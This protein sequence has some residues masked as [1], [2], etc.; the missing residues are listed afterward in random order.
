MA[1]AQIRTT[2]APVFA[3][4]VLRRL[5][6]A[7]AVSAVGD[8]MSAVGVAWLAIRI[9]S[10]ADS[11]LVVGV[12]VAAYTL[13]GA[14]G[15]V[16]LARPLRALSGRHLVAADAALRAVTL[17]MIPLLYAF[18]ALRAGSYVALLA[19]S[20]LLH[21]WGIS[22]QYTLVA[23]HLP[24]QSR[25]AANSLLSGAG[26]AALVIG[27]LLAGLLVA[28]A[29]PAL[30]VAA[31]AA[32]FAIRAVAAATARGHRPTARPADAG[33]ADAGQPDRAAGFAAIARSRPLAGLL[34]LTVVYFFL[35]GP[36]E[37]ALPLYVTGPLGGG[38]GLLGL[39]WTV[40]GIG[41]TA[42]SII[43]GLARRLPVW[44]VLVAA[45]IG[46]GAV[47]TPL[48]LL[49]LAIPALACFAAGGLL[50]APYPALSATLFQ[51]ESPPQL[52]SQ[53]LAARG[54]LTVLAAPL[55]TALGGPLTTWLGAQHT[56]LAS[57]AA[58][59]ATGLAATAILITR[60]PSRIGGYAR[61]F[62]RSAREGP[63]A[64]NPSLPSAAAATRSPNPGL[65]KT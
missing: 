28:A 51:R 54:A 61:I 4:P 2:V 27:P 29:G 17:S 43:A 22:G 11:G 24:P 37:V 18:G 6:P 12:A 40:F 42:G 48:G 55:G 52:L 59:I 15:A 45:V 3:S 10:P 31:D 33:P 13:P 62:R 58:T 7:F 30:P 38:A 23:E 39:F 60:H 44:P 41:A 50:Y 46:W 57:G 35:Y 34:A 26:M 25:T 14:A 53:V 8:G 36:V 9:A 64:A 47:L 5:L 21:A 16:L 65:L 1:A 49:R 19:A 32:S 20:S 63:G 56:L